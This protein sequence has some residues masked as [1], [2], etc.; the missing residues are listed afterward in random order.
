MS[1]RAIDPLQ[2]P[3]SLW[4]RAEML[5]AL[6]TRDVG[7]VF[8]LVRQFVGASQTQIA[9]A[10]GTTQGKVSEIM[11][12]GGRR[13]ES[14]EV[15]ERIA[16]GLQM[17]DEAR[18]VLGLAPRDYQPP[19]T[20]AATPRRKRPVIRSRDDRPEL[21]QATPPGSLGTD[22]PY[23]GEDEDPV[24]RR[25]FF[26][27]LASA[28]L[29]SSILSDLPDGTE[30]LDGVEGLAAALTAYSADTP[31]PTAL[32]LRKL[33][34]A[35]ITAKRDYQACRYTKVI[36][37]LPRLLAALRAGSEVFD[38]DALLKLHELSAEAHHVAASILLK[39]DDEGPAWLAAERSMQAAN[40]SQ[41]P[42]IVGSSARIITH[43]LMKG[44]RHGAAA[45]MASK[46]A[47]RLDHDMD[48]QTPESLSVY[49]SLLLRGAVAAGKRPDHDTANALLDEAGNAARQ[50][51]GDH[52]HR[53]TAFGPTN[54]QLHRVNVA[55][56]LGNAG[57]ALQEAR[58]VNLDQV[59]ITERKAVLLLDTAR[60]LTQWGKHERA[61]HA[62]RA[63]E[64]LAPEEVTSRPAGR[65]LVREL[66]TTAPPSLKREIREYAQQIGVHG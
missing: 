52:N 6:R 49:G 47:E 62:I 45:T 38:G 24:R 63:A 12:K 51:G 10:C 35:V 56:T 27:G 42:I 54:V 17:P 18:M 25:T 29:F 46:F 55:V 44:K 8:R 23:E 39:Y 31:D 30:P 19:A 15:F 64:Q 22:L 14:L 5:T 20:P 4:G 43:A 16:D 3:M 28:G 21:S 60:A 59:P 61:Y 66:A 1:G 33:E 65:R 57:T 11:R 34:P 48:T 2:I 53:W 7:Q 32:D 9:I 26:A 41:N 36:R 13:V 50:L 58:R 40:H 37:D